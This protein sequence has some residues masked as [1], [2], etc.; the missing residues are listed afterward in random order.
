MI[1]A[2]IVSRLEPTTPMH[3]AISLPVRSAD[4]V[5]RRVRAVSDPES[6][7]YRHYL[8]PE[9][10]AQAYG[11]SQ[12]D[13]E[14]IAAWAEARGLSVERAFPNRLVLAVTGTAEAVEKALYVQMHTRERADGTRFFT[15][16]R[17][18]SVDLAVPILRVEGLDD[19]VRPRPG[20]CAISS[21]ATTGTVVLCQDG[22]SPTLQQNI[23][24]LY[25][26]TEL[27][28]AYLGGTTCA[29]L[30]GEKQTVAIV[31]HEGFDQRGLAAYA[32][33]NGLTT[34]T[35]V[36]PLNNWGP[37]SNN[38][39]ETALDV[40]M[41]TA[42]APAA[43]IAVHE[44]NNFTPILA[45]VA[46]TQPLALQVSD[47]W[48]GEL[49][50]PA[51]Q[52][53]LDELAL[54]GQSY[55]LL[56]GDNQGYTA[57][58]DARA[59]SNVTIVGGTM[60]G[61]NWGQPGASYYQAEAGWVEQQVQGLGSG[62]GYLGGSNPV[63][64][65]YYQNWLPQ[66]GSQ[67][68]MRYRNLPD[69]SMVGY[70]VAIF[71]GPA[72]GGATY[73]DGT[74]VSTPLW[75]AMM[76]LV[77]EAST[78]GPV[79]FAN[80]ALYSI[81]QK[82]PSAFRDPAVDPFTPGFPAGVFPT[83]PG[84]DLVT[85]LGTPTCQ[86]VNTLA[87]TTNAHSPTT[88]MPSGFKTYGGVGNLCLAPASDSVA[89]GARLVSETC[90]SALPAQNWVLAYGH[91]AVSPATNTKLCID[92]NT[93]TGIVSLQPCSGSLSQ[94]WT[95]GNNIMSGV[96][97]TKNCL[98]VPSQTSGAVVG[99]AACNEEER[100]DFWPWGFPMALT[101]YGSSQCLNNVGLGQSL[102]DANCRP[103]PGAPPVSVVVRSTETNQILLSGA[104]L[105]SSGDYGESLCANLDGLRALNG[106]KPYYSPVTTQPC[107]ASSS[108]SSQQW[109]FNQAGV[110]SGNPSYAVVRSWGNAADGTPECLDVK[111]GSTLSGAQV[112]VWQCNGTGAQVWQLSML[113]SDE[114]GFTGY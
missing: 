92:W 104:Y 20:A 73:S 57:Q 86:L 81:A 42:M 22:S 5:A 88:L 51:S 18:P 39:V 113:L 3:L 37:P 31:A 60:L 15:A 49:L 16:D 53:L 25:K 100:Q 35:T 63:P 109:Y 84:Y 48:T 102:D 111:S 26:G 33:A 87:G 46:T 56:S 21:Q 107:G 65:P 69:V 43:T 99:V 27:R 77:N 90:N 61:V 78:S 96:G 105:N 17:E 83:V 2:P 19:F 23:K 108:T 93:T 71:T 47:S 75:A 40:E 94:T 54:Q 72:P 62:G 38:D 80:P 55:L 98:D 110:H 14:S 30:K 29:S 32:Q 13:Y 1:A 82:T 112:D 101:N 103:T 74:S 114:I 44:D 85:G 41:V 66:N 70:H 106:S 28:N 58:G 45:S 68:S 10:Y 89:S 95:V 7:S 91:G 8:T 52:Q 12:E 36:F 4:E 67:A 79:G 76:S 11:P 59:A 9:E 6:P 97:G 64:L 50:G 34:P 24:G